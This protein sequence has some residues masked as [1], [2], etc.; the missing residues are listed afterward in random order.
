[1]IKK[2]LV[3]FFMPHSVYGIAILSTDIIRRYRWKHSVIPPIAT[4]VTARGPYVCLLVFHT[5]AP[6]GLVA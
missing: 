3:C 2:I 5:R 1:M 4:D 6:C